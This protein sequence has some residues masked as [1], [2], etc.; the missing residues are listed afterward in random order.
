MT[1][2][3]SFAYNCIPVIIALVL[4]TLW[5]FIDFDVLLSNRTFRSPARKDVLRRCSSEITTLVRASS[6]P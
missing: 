6:L 1:L 5:S 4:S 3:Q 2:A